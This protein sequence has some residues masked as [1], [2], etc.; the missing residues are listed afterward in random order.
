MNSSWSNPSFPE[1]PLKHIGNGHVCHVSGVQMG[2]HCLLE[3]S[4]F[5]DHLA[6]SFGSNLDA[7]SHSLDPVELFDSTQLK[8]GMLEASLISQSRAPGV[9]QWMT[10]WSG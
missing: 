10:S 9:L 4:L 1:W 3:G 6:G 7:F 5:Q 2:R 8:A